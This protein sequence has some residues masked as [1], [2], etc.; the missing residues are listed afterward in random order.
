MNY[1]EAVFKSCIHVYFISIPIDNLYSI[2]WEQI[3][4]RVAQLV[5]RKPQGRGCYS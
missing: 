1:F 3:H 5:K 4:K 2:Y